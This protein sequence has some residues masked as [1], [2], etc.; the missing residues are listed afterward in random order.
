MS[1]HALVAFFAVAVL[2]MVDADWFRAIAR[3]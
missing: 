1:K 3:I 2:E